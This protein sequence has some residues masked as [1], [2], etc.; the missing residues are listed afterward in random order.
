V[1]LPDPLYCAPEMP[2][3]SVLLAPLR[4]FFRPVAFE[5]TAFSS[6][7]GAF[8]GGGGATTVGGGGGAFGVDKH[9]VKSLLV[10]RHLVSFPYGV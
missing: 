8:S 9:R 7:A 6:S 3:P 4:L 1:P 5:S 10:G 2:R